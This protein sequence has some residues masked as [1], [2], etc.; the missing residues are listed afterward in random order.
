VGL[1]NLSP[2][3]TWVELSAMK[4]GKRPMAKLW[5]HHFL[6]PKIW[7]WFPTATEACPSGWCRTVLGLHCLC[8]TW[9]RKACFNGIGELGISYPLTN[10]SQSV[11][12]PGLE[13]RQSLH[14]VYC[15]EVWAWSPESGGCWHQQVSSSG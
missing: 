5:C 7:P 2:Y 3:D 14:G 11:K 4:W 15:S 10:P 6:C 8:F 12:F 13:E 9:C 1:V